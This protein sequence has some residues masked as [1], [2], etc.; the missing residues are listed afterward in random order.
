MMS[1]MTINEGEIDKAL[2]VSAD[3]GELNKVLAYIDE[4]LEEAGCPLKVQMQI[5]VATEEIFV[6]IANY[7]YG[8]DG[9]SVIIWMDLNDS[10][11]AVISF[12]D[13]GVEFDPL[14][15]QDPDTTLSADERQIGGLGIYMV[16]KSMDQVKYKRDGDK[17]ILTIHKTW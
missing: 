17:N 9:G 12:I 1:E 11:E 8:Y 16:K 15:K 6:N 7:A 4:R 14:K 13:T 2:N 3:V 10:P 5:D